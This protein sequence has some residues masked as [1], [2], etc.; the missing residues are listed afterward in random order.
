MGAIAMPLAIGGMAAGTGISMYGQYR[1]GKQAQEIGEYNAQIDEMR[2][3]QMRRNAKFAEANARF[4]KENARTAAQI[5]ADKGRRLIATQ[6]SRAAAGGVRVDIGQPL[7]TEA[8]TKEAIGRDVAGIMRQG[9]QRAKSWMN[10]AGNYMSE[11]NVFTQSAAIEREMGDNARK[12][13]IWNMVGTGLTGAGSIAFMGYNSGFFNN[14]GLK[15][16]Q[17][18]ISKSG[19]L[20]NVADSVY[21]GWM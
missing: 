5:Q 17:R 20:S 1:Q 14:W 4:E 3:E 15:G 18:L 10:Q 2:A 7:V 8:E 19:G 6:K 11:A 12:N 16:N 13:S 21:S 9:S